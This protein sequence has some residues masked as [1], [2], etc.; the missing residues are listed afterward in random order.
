M[1]SQQFEVRFY[2]IIDFFI[3]V[4]GNVK[5]DDKLYLRGNYFE[6]FEKFTK[7]VVYQPPF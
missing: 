6:S 1:K 4:V 2:Q 7:R 3:T 5:A